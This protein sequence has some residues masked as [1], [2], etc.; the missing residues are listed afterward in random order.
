MPLRGVLFDLGGTLLHYNAPNTSWED[1]EKT[2]AR[3]VYR[4]LHGEGYTLPSESEALD[5]AWD[6]ALAFW[7]QV[8]NHYDPKTLK[9]DRFV[10]SLAARWSINGLPDTLVESLGVDFM[11][12]IQAQVYPLDG[13]ADTLHTLRDRGL[14]IGLISNTLWPGRV[15]LEDLERHG[16][17]SYVEHTI[18]SA[19]VEAWKPHPEVFQLGLDSLNLKPGETIF[20]GDAMYH[21]IWGAQQVGMRSVWIEHERTWLPEGIV[22][23]PDASVRRLPDLI[24]IVS[25]WQ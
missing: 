25:G 19:D 4:R 12:A 15:H 2:G 23:R 24:E 10:R 9:L 7:S 20:V 13:A 21:D 22:V 3:E 1:T 18:F 14:R 17:I 6:H 8:T 5:T 16:L 11:R